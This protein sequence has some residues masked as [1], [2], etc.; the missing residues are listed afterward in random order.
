MKWNET[1]KATLWCIGI[2]FVIGYF[3]NFLSSTYWWD[4]HAAVR[5][6]L[7]YSAFNFPLALALNGRINMCSSRTSESST[8]RSASMTSSCDDCRQIRPHNSHVHNCHDWDVGGLTS[9]YV[10]SHSLAL[11]DC[12]QQYLMTSVRHFAPNSQLP[13]ILSQALRLA[14]VGLS[15]FDHNFSENLST[16]CTAV[17]WY[18]TELA[19]FQT[20]TPCPGKKQQWIDWLSWNFTQTFQI[21]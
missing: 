10:E 21:A 5:C 20:Y 9:G 3:R 19:L 6:S 11:L 1:D 14:C 7:Q 2:L 12:S 15:C 4:L 18:L 13:G 8:C 17:S 16:V